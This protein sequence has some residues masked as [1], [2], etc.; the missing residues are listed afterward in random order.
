MQLARLRDPT[1]TFI[2]L[3]GKPSRHIQLWLCKI[4]S[5]IAVD[6]CRSQNRTRRSASKASRTSC[7]SASTSS[8]SSRESDRSWDFE[9]HWIS[10]VTIAILVHWTLAGASTLTSTCRSACN[11]SS[12]NAAINGHQVDLR[13]GR[14]WFS[15][16]LGLGSSMV[17]PLHFPHSLTCKLAQSLWQPP[18]AGNL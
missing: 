18:N 16:A 7:S 11:V 1:Q 6:I 4:H 2:S 15:M 12:V 13:L 8:T 5:L 17:Q 3:S 9:Y 10:L 14:T